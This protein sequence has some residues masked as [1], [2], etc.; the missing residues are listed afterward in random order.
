[1]RGFCAGASAAELV[2]AGGGGS[3]HDV[4]EVDVAASDGECG[5]D[6]D[7]ED[8][9]DGDGDAEG[10]RDGDVDTGDMTT[11]PAAAAVAAT[12]GR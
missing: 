10:E 3:S 11:A 4:G 9:G 5:G 6:V 1:M 7:G 2:D 12:G 8:V